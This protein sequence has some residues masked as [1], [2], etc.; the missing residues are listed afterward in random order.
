MVSILAVPAFCQAQEVSLTL[1]EAVTFALRENRD[2]LLKAEDVKK[3]KFRISEAQAGVFPGLNA[4]AGWYDTRG[5][6]SKDVGGYTA[7]V[8]V[9]QILYKG[10]K[11]VSAIKASE[12]AYTA[13]EAILD[14]ARQDVVFNVKKVFYT[15]ALSEEL[16]GINKGI[17]DNT[18]EHQDF[19]QARYKQG[20]ASRSD[21]LRMRSSVSDVAQAYKAAVNQ[22]EAALQVLRNLLY[23]DNNIEIKPQ[24][25]FA[26]S[27]QD[28][29]Y[30]KAFIKAMQNRP[31]IR[32]LDAQE[33][34][35]VQNVKVAR[36][37]S[38]PSVFASWDYY[39]RSTALTGTSRG[40]NDYNIVGITVSWP[41][42]D[43]WLT[44]ARVEQALV[45]VKQSQLLKEQANK[46]IALDV[47]TA[48]LEF[49]NALD[50]I[51]AREDQ[52]AVYKDTY[53]VIQ[54]QY[55]EGLAS[56][57]DLH[58]ALQAYHIALFNETQAIYDYMIAKIQF[59]RATGG[60][61]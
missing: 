16:I 58:D 56:Q 37:D 60:V 38:R 54:K 14:K 5:L 33:K 46:D 44:K 31:E 49:R 30:D 32:Q 26:Y 1:D 2:I 10:G 57:L 15:A 18:K 28:V 12:Y 34:A 55:K 7:Q 45:D 40:W 47:K 24:A 6:Y 9:K 36:A 27:A 25:A 52:V 3:A 48:Y 53:E 11:I 41:V 4:A 23:L 51:G 29:A 59:D 20:Q 43:G 61:I 19:I 13:T 35:S 39:S 17:L 50:G 22:H 42:F 21:A 8:G